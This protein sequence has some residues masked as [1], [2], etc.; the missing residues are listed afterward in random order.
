[1]GTLYWDLS[2]KALQH[3]LKTKW[4][5]TKVN[6]TAVGSYDIFPLHWTIFCKVCKYLYC[7]Y[8]FLSKRSMPDLSS[9]DCN[10]AGCEINLFSA[11]MP[12][13]IDP[14]FEWLNL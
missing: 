8:E 4:I 10:N 6:K 3:L 5:Y 14:E 1:M 9:I 13:N 2:A 7:I 11:H 12:L